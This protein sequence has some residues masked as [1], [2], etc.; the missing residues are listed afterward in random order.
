VRQPVAE[1]ID[2][3]KRDVLSSRLPKPA[4]C[5]D[6][7]D[8]SRHHRLVRRAMAAPLPASRV[9]LGAPSRASAG[10]RSPS[11]SS[12]SP[13]WRHRDGCPK[14]T[15]R[16]NASTSERNLYPSGRSGPAAEHS[17]PPANSST[18]SPPR[19]RR[20]HEDPLP[21]SNAAF[22]VELKLRKPGPPGR[23]VCI[24]IP[25]PAR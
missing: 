6:Q 16:P 21:T 13:R 12:G 19:R 1:K 3:R 10:T 22:D 25:R 23:V 18:R 14:C 15:M 7:V 4:S 9:M 17:P 24:V 8:R 11:P 20:Q 5:S 2:G